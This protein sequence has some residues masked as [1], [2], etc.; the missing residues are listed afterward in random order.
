M[1]FGWF[2]SSSQEQSNLQDESA[3]SSP[4]PFAPTIILDHV[5]FYLYSSI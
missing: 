2:G 1:S 5:R 4:E 3:S